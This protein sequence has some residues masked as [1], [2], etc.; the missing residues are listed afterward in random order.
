[1]SRSSRSW[2]ARI[3]SAAARMDSSEARSSRTKGTV[4]SGT[5]AD[6]LVSASSARPASRQAS[7]VCAPRR[8]STVAASKPIPEFAPVTTATRPLWSGTSATVQGPC[9]TLIGACPPAVPAP[10]LTDKGLAV[11]RPCR[12]RTGAGWRAGLAG[13]PRG[14]G[15]GGY[16]RNHVHAYPQPRGQ[17]LPYRPGVRPLLRA[18]VCDRDHPGDPDHPAA[19][20]AHGWRPGARRGC[21][22]VGG[23]G[24]HYRRPD[25]LRH[26]HAEVHPASLVRDLRGVGR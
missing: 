21:R 20:A 19:L 26:H 6:S 9:L 2:V 22:P 13:T 14:H 15:R 24:R 7:T 12:G 18:D 23:S 3:W 17:R 25:L 8:A 11:A 1:M 16:A 5:A 4:A 10:L